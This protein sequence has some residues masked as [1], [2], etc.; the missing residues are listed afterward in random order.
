LALH[1]NILIGIDQL[2][3]ALLLGDPDET[4]SSRAYKNRAYWPWRWLCWALNKIDSNHCKES[5]EADE[6]ADQLTKR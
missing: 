2:F 3:N 4:I 5:L 1:Q 6:G